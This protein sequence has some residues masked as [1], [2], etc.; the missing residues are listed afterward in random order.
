MSGALFLIVASHSVLICLSAIALSLCAIRLLEGT[1]QTIIH[2]IR[3]LRWFVIPILLLHALLTPG[4]LLFPGIAIP[5]TREGIHQGIWLSLRLAAIFVAAILL[6]RILLRR[7]WLQGMMLSPFLA[8]RLMAHLL[9]IMPVKN[10]IG[11]QLRYLRQQWQLRKDW[12]KFPLFLLSSFRMATGAGLEQARMLW[13][14]WPDNAESLPGETRLKS[15]NLTV[16][17]GICSSLALTLLGLAEIAAAWH[18]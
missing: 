6:S 7:E 11:E 15:L 2:L 12:K 14:R 8:R 17:H 5:L 4:Q 3:L 16:A 1:W 18:L 13:L 9:M 10:S